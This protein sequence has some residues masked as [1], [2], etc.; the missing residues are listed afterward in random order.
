MKLG[1]FFSNRRI[2]AFIVIFPPIIL[3]FYA[4][5][6]YTLFFKSVKVNQEKVIYHYQDSIYDITEKILKSK[7]ISINNVIDNLDLPNLIKVLKSIEIDDNVNFIILDK[8]GKIF[9]KSKPLSKEYIDRLSKLDGEYKDNRYFFFITKKN[10]LGMR[11]IF[12]KDVKSIYSSLNLLNKEIRADTAKDARYNLYLFISIWILLLILSLLLSIMVFN[13]LKR[14]EKEL[15]AKNEKI[16]LNSKQAL[17]GELLPMIAHQWRQPLNKVASILMSMRF[18]I[19]KKNPNK[20]I[21]DMQ[22][23]EIEDSV[24]LMSQTIDDFRTFYRPK[25]EPKVVD[26]ALLIRKSLFFLDEL[27]SRKKI[28][29][30][31]SLPTLYAKIYENEFL[32][33]LINLIKN[34]SDAVSVKGSINIILREIEGNKVEIRVEDDGVGIPE[35]KIEKIFEAHE[36]SKEASMGLGLYMSKIIIENRLGGKIRAYNTPKGAGFVIVLDKFTKEEEN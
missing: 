17:L 36:S 2:S 25:K 34:A 10:H 18:E 14:Y 28:R 20:N 6:S 4:L 22:S 5:L 3:L 24:E 23:Q 7:A 29:I 19:S 21:L 8:S 26:L 9:F 32:Q 35:D 30:S 1:P 11:V 33:V 16:I 27:L 12:F 13:R 31:H 15:E